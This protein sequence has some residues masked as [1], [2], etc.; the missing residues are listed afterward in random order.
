MKRITAHVITLLS[1]VA[2]ALG[3]AA[4]LRGAWMPVG[5]PGQTL[6]D[7]TSAALVLAGAYWPPIVLT[8]LLTGSVVLALTR[9]RRMA[10]S[11]L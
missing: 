4:T 11:D 1:I 8:G 3:A 2:L 6:G 10:G 5:F 9:Q 7:A